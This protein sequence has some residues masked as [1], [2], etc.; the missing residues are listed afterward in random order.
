MRKLVVRIYGS[1]SEIDLDGFY[2]EDEEL[3]RD[4]LYDGFIHEIITQPSYYWVV[5]DENGKEVEVL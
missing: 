5:V 4:S 1:E 3:D 2:D